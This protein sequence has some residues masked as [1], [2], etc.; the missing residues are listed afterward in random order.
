MAPL[1]IGLVVVA[2]SWLAVHNTAGVYIFACFYGI[3]A[4]AFQSLLPTTAASLTDDMKKIGTRLGMVFSSMSFA[5]LTGPPIGGA[6]VQATGGSYV[7]AQAWAASGA[8]VCAVVFVCARMS[9]AK[10][11]LRAKV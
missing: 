10:W 2:W 5:A 7:A 11:K 6:I 1:C 4:A 3:H 9:K 8:T